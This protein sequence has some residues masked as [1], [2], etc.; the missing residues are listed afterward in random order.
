MAGRAWFLEASLHCSLARQ[1]VL[2]VMAR[3]VGIPVTELFA[4]LVAE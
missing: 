3:A 1:S 2:A 4:D